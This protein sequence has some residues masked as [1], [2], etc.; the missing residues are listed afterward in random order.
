MPEFRTADLTIQPKNGETLADLEQSIEG[1]KL[2]VRK[3]SLK[4]RIGDGGDVEYLLCLAGIST[5]Q[6]VAGLGSTSNDCYGQRTYEPPNGMGEV[7]RFTDYMRRSGK[8]GVTDVKWDT[9]A[10]SNE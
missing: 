2:R 9:E 6:M 4:E 7:G 10:N 1:L 5:Q 3:T 8:F